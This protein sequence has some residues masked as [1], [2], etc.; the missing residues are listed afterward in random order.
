M[1]ALCN[2]FEVWRQR[3]SD[4]YASGRTFGR[5]WD[6]ETARRASRTRVF[7]SVVSRWESN[8]WLQVVLSSAIVAI[9][10][11]RR[12]HV[13]PECSHYVLG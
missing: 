11:R 8:G 4:E 6:R 7:W 3:F 12:T 5:E 2:G 13:F 9:G 1:F 10:K